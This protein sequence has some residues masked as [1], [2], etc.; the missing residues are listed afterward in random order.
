M[1][2]DTL[3]M[4]SPSPVKAVGMPMR[5]GCQVWVVTHSIQAVRCLIIAG[6]K[7]EVMLY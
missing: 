2:R 5:M 3:E 1:P 7:A 6:G 4:P